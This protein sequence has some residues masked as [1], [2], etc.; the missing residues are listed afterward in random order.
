MSKAFKFELLTIESFS[1][2]LY[3]YHRSYKKVASIKIYDQG[4]VLYNIDSSYLEIN[5][6]TVNCFLQ[7]LTINGKLKK[8]E[9]IDLYSYDNFFIKTSIEYKSGFDVYI[10]LKNIDCY[11]LGTT[12][13]DHNL[14]VTIHD[15]IQI[16]ENGIDNNNRH[17]ISFQVNC[18]YR[19][20]ETSLLKS[21]NELIKVMTETKEYYFCHIHD[22]SVQQLIESG[23][24]K[25]DRE[26]LERMKANKSNKYINN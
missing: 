2:A 16:N 4:E 1:K 22:Y 6:S 7:K 23:I 3:F 26:V 14:T 15:T 20:K 17:L 24:V 13:L 25:I 11:F 5:D 9:M 19:S 21:I 12:E 18:N 10:N 8:K